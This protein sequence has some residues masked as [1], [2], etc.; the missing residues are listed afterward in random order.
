MALHPRHAVSVCSGYGGLDLGLRLALGGSCRTIL[1][2]EREAFAAAVLVAQMGL[3]R[4]VFAR[5]AAK[6]IWGSGISL[7]RFYVTVVVFNSISSKAM[8]V[9]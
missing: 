7:R 9:T 6:K 1:Y 4:Y 3:T 2:C 8:E 5:N